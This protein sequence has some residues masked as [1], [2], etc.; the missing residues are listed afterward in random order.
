MPGLRETHEKVD[1][2]ELI[3]ISFVDCGFYL[4]AFVVVP[5]TLFV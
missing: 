1:G 4:R 3:Q 2:E 5:F